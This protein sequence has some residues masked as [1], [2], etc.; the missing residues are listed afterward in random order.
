MF[1]TLDASSL[2]EL[3]S[4]A[5]R[6]KSG[7]SIHNLIG[8]TDKKTRSKTGCLN[9]RH[10]RKKKCDE[11]HPICGSCKARNLECVWGIQEYNPT[12]IKDSS[13]RIE[14]STNRKVKP[15]SLKA[16][17]EVLK[18][19]S[20]GK[21]SRDLPTSVDEII[22]KLSNK[23]DINPVQSSNELPNNLSQAVFELPSSEAVIE[24]PN[25]ESIIELET[26]T[27]SYRSPFTQFDPSSFSPF[28]KSPPF[29]PSTPDPIDLNQDFDE[30]SAWINPSI[31]Y[32]PSNTFN[33]HLDEKGLILLDIY[34]TKISKM[35]SIS[36]EA[37]NYFLKTFFTLAATEESVLNLLAA[38]G[39]VLYDGP[40]SATVKH[41]K[42]KSQ[43]LLA[44][45]F[46][47]KSRLDKFDY[48]TLF[49]YYLIDIGSEIF[50]GDTSKWHES[51][52]KANKLLIGYGSVTKFLEDFNYSND[53]KFLISNY[54]FHDI[55]SSETLTAGTSCK[56]GTYLNIFDDDEDLSSYGLDPYQG[57]IQP[58]FL[59]LGEI[60]NTSVECKQMRHKLNEKMDGLSKDILIDVPRWYGVNEERIKYFVDVDIKSRELLTKVENCSPN[61]IQV[62][63]LSKNMK[64]LE[65]HLTLFE[66]YRNT[67]KIYLLL[68]IKQ[69][70]PKSSEIQFLLLDSFK[71]LDV[72]MHSNLTTSLVMALLVCGMCCTTE[73]DRLEIRNKFERVYSCCKV[74][75]VTKALRIVEECWRQNPDGEL[76]ID[77]VSICEDFGWK[78][79]VC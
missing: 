11:I 66:L 29:L 44:K 9:C 64:D 49:A 56:I 50:S 18:G 33:L 65:N 16:T 10:K 13:H 32:T 6:L 73:L 2:K 15:F 4:Q 35:I 21:S 74:G 70:Q 76:C 20:E 24:L 55:M 71:L 31:L 5:P 51:F 43:T 78:L 38:W 61:N 28:F 8:S 60:L 57:C 34:K 47:N 42:Q 25:S 39:G 63:I 3:N 75:N 40:D 45:R 19:S 36:G 52:L 48:F 58:L 30:T 79:S 46:E 77:W 72:L 54:Q 22:I 69:T 26:S 17:R 67:C 23:E 27:T 68:Y 14:K 12:S 41:Y 7:V 1:S 62:K 59:L 37:S 53:A